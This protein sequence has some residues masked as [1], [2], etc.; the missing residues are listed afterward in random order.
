MRVA[1]PSPLMLSADEQAMSATM[2]G[3]WTQFAKTGDPNGSGSPM[4]PVLHDGE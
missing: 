4:W 3:Y 1:I 2:V